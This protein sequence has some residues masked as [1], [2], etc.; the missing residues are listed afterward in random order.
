MTALHKGDIET[1]IFSREKNPLDVSGM[2][3]ELKP[4]LEQA[5]RSQE[6]L[7]PNDYYQGK[8]WVLFWSL[9]IKRELFSQ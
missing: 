5:Y 6:E 7:L 8:F 2:E 9:K 3:E 4:Q 1:S